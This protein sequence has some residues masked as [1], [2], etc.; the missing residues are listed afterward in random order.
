M[1]QHIAPGGALPAD[2]LSRSAAA[3]YLGVTH[4]SLRKWQARGRGPRITFLPSGAAGYLVDDLD[5]FMLTDDYPSEDR[6]REARMAVAAR[7]AKEGARER[8]RNALLA[9]EMVAA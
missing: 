2:C 1:S 9:N 5:A 8:H 7:W 4:L 6:R 3:R